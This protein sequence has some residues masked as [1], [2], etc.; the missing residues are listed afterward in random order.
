MA[1]VSVDFQDVVQALLNEDQLFSLRERRH[2]TRE[3][4]VRQVTLVMLER[5]N[6]RLTG[7]TRNL[8]LNGLGLI[9]KFPVDVDQKA[10]LSIHRLWD[11]PI[12]LKCD[13]CWT[14]DGQPGWYQSGWNILSVEFAE[15]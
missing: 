14:N 3:S 2:H 11:S 12:V 8:S 4:F 15:I 1:N 9:H 10:L 13:V 5:P 6:T 7:F